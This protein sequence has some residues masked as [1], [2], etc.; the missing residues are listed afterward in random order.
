MTTPSEDSGWRKGDKTS[1]G[2]DAYSLLE[3]AHAVQVKEIE[4]LAA[5]LA[6]R[7][8]QR[9]NQR[10]KIAALV[11]IQ[12]DDRRQVTDCG[13][14]VAA[15]N[16]TIENQ[17]AALARQEA[18][19]RQLRQERSETE[20]GDQRNLTSVHDLED[21]L[22]GLKVEHEKLRQANYEL[23]RAKGTAEVLLK[24]EQGAVAE[25][26]EQL[27]NAQR[28][29]VEAET[30]ASRLAQQ[31]DMLRERDVLDDEIILD[32]KTK[33]ANL[34]KSLD[35]ARR[36]L[37]EAANKSYKPSML[38]DALQQ[39]Q[40]AVLG[41]LEVTSNAGSGLRKVAEARRLQRLKYS[42]QH[43]YDRHGTTDLI[44]AA[45]ALLTLDPSYWPREFDRDT[46][47]ELASE[48]TDRLAAAGAFCCAVLDVMEHHKRQ[49]ESR[50]GQ[51]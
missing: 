42:V 16:I 26:R 33:V 12:E 22:Q 47:A 41:T 9:D 50:I 2:L 36:N 4:S 15:Q 3:Q 31:N 10:L 1:Q 35:A 24:T 8:A 44:N 39:I 45:V 51:S 20:Q 37:A 32:L 27:Q 28:R 11:K 46:Y 17:T 7:T 19:L 34:E 29:V 5:Q 48:D 23:L 18:V 13:H 38:T 43:D 25:L 6:H 49:E 14:L 30:N 21:E 40:D